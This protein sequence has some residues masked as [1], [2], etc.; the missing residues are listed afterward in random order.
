MENLINLKSF[1]EYTNES[2]ELDEDLDLF[3]DEDLELDEDLDLEDSDDELDE[4][5]RINA[6]QKKKRAFA[7]DLARQLKNRPA[8]M[9]AA[10][11]FAIVLKKEAIAAVRESGGRIK[12]IALK[13]LGKVNLKEILGTK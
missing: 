7:S 1:D 3:E 4:G 13:N 5:L 10:K 11:K 2:L 6:A 12:P 9:A 8:Y